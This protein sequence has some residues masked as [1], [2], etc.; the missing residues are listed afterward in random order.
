V[1]RHPAATGPHGCKTIDHIGD[2]SCNT[3]TQSSAVPRPAGVGKTTLAHIIARHCGYRVVEINASDER[4]RPAL[5]KAVAA[6]VQMQPVLGERRP[7]C[8]VIDEIDGAI[9]GD[10]ARSG[11]S[12]VGAVADLMKRG[13][14]EPDMGGGGRRRKHAEP[15]QRPII[16]ICNDL[17]APALRPLREVVDVIL[18]APPDV[19]ALTSRLREVC[20]REH[21]DVAEQVCSVLL[22]AHALLTIRPRNGQFAWTQKGHCSLCMLAPLFA[23]CVQNHKCHHCILSLSLYPL[24]L[25]ARQHDCSLHLQAL[26]LLATKTNGDVRSSLNTLQLLAARHGR[27]LSSHIADASIGQKDMRAAPFEVWQALMH[28]RDDRPGDMFGYLM[29]FGEHSMVR[30]PHGNAI[31]IVNALVW[32]PCYLGSTAWLVLLETGNILC[33]N[34]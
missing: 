24:C 16:C 17:Y 15:L 1:A 22:L 2:S 26:K 23:P 21:V 5:L 7:N 6:A 4:S 30:R 19:P 10:G 11:S 14:V 34:I 9:G 29:S 12:A 20:N 32:A 28:L 25:H 27:I 3:R 33:C 13:T 31:A 18:L 8:L